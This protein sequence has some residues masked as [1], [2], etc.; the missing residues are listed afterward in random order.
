MF[1]STKGQ[2][3]PCGM[4]SI[5]H[6][7]LIIITSSAIY[8]AIKYTKNKDEKQ[9]SK[10]IRIFTIL[11]C[12]LEILKILFVLL[13][14]KAKNVN[15]FLPLYYCSLLIYAGLLSSFGKGKFKKTGDVFLATGAMVGGVVFILFPT[16]TLPSYPML[17]CLSLYSFFFHGIMVYL[18]LI[19][20][21]T[22]YIK[23][24]KSD[25]KYY[26]ILVAI[27][28]IIA[29]LI[30][31]KFNSNLMFISRNFPGTILEVFYNILG[32]FYTPFISL[33]QIVLPF[34]FVY[35]N[36]KL[37]IKIHTYIHNKD[38]VFKKKII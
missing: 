28:C 10:I 16:T 31:T 20:N 21:I 33:V 26:A 3:P 17:H 34:Y 18:G 19:I 38:K 12:N 6:L 32:V 23:L 24:E 37:I 15:E 13:I 22:N 4:F 25:I 14:E 2:Y 7:I 36:K 9:I 35:Y 5:G 27:I 30:N 29:Y 1:F 8:I 11:I